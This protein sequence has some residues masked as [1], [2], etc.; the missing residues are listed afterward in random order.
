MNSQAKGHLPKRLGWKG[1]QYQRDFV[2]W[3]CEWSWVKGVYCTRGATRVSLML[4]C[5]L[6]ASQLT[7]LCWLWCCCSV[8]P[9]V[10]LN[11]PLTVKDQLG[12]CA[13]GSSG[14]SEG[15]QETSV[16]ACLPYSTTNSCLHLP[17][18]PLEGVFEKQHAIIL[19][20]PVPTT[21][22]R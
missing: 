18:F 2:L 14:L 9:G 10:S 19:K 21:E 12:T 7:H 15:L 16:S 22:R 5:I 11:L 3:K 13:E 6:G 20:P 1:Y 17:S 8:V 4:A